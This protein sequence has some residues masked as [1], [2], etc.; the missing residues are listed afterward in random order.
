MAFSAPTK[1]IV[2]DWNGSNL[3]IR[4]RARRVKIEREGKHRMIRTGAAPLQQAG[5]QKFAKNEN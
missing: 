1:L 3:G 5:R 4:L 2:K